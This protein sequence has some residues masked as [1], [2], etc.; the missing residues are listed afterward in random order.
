MRPCR[1][2][3]APTRRNV[4]PMHIDIYGDTI[5]PWCQIGKA[6]FTQ[7]I[8]TRAGRDIEIAWRA[9]QLNPEMPEE[10]LAR[11]E[12]LTLKFGSVERGNRV[13]DRIAEAGRAEGL[14]F[15]FARIARIP[16]TL[17]SHR[18]VRHAAGED[19]EQPIL[20]ALAHGFFVEGADIG[21]PDTLAAIGRDTGL[22]PGALDAMLASD[23]HLD[24][25]RAEDRRAR[26][27]G[28]EGVP[29]FV[30]DSRFSVAGAQEKEVFA[31][32]LDLAPVPRPTDV[33]SSSDL[34]SSI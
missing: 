8:E 9:F 11:D 25:V 13:Y 34:V 22:E 24:D 27:L 14:T 2:R 7:A 18:L 33:K 6:R 20:D 31:N 5:C 26:R 17:M 4:T 30:F 19:L 16:N 32:M 15:R 12:Y 3:A 29:T 10:G 23:A 21:D 1:L 28:L